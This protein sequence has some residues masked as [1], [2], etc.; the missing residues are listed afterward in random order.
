MKNVILLFISL[1]VLV[2][3]RTVPAE[4]VSDTEYKIVSS[5]QNLKN[6]Y[7]I[8]KLNDRYYLISNKIDS[9][10]YLV[11]ID[12]ENIDDFNKIELSGKANFEV[13]NFKN[14]I[15]ASNGA[16]RILFNIS[17]YE[18]KSKSL[19]LNAFNPTRIINVAGITTTTLSRNELTYYYEDLFPT[20]GGG[21][22]S[23]ISCTSGGPGSSHCAVNSGVGPISNGCEVTCKSG[24]YACCDDGRTI[25]KCVKGN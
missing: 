1:I 11:L 10:K 5:N 13:N 19:A 25:C 3:C 8:E 23:S 20:D 6:D 2:S 18:Y 21:G 24:Y 14:Y 7:A 16:E 15:T 9:I 4:I 17:S 22:S 12:D